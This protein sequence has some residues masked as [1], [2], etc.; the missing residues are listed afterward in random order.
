MYY[1]LTDSFSLHGNQSL[2][3][4]SSR[5]VYRLRSGY[6]QY[7]ASTIC[8]QH[9][10]EP[11]LNFLSSCSNAYSKLLYSLYTLDKNIIAKC[12][13]PKKLWHNA[14][15][16]LQKYRTVGLLGVEL[17]SSRPLPLCD[18]TKLLSSLPPYFTTISFHFPLPLAYISSLLLKCHVMHRLR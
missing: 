11:F 16:F 10:S 4:G 1:L 13:T 8:T 18:Q 6:R 17:S 7:D 14:F 5:H 12:C 2:Y 3:H 9:F 15:F